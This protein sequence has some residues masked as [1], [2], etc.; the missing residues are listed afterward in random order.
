MLKYI[1][2][3]VLISLLTMLFLIIATFFLMRIIPGSPFI[4]DDESVAA[5]KQYEQLNAKYGLDKPLMEQFGIYMKGLLHGDMGDSLIKKGKSVADIIANTAVVTMRLGLVAFVFSMIVGMALGIT[6]A[7]SKSRALNNFVMLLS[8]IGVSVP[9]FLLAVFLMIVFAVNL[10]IFPTVGL[11]TPLHYVLPTIAVSLHPIAMISRLTR[12]SMMEVMRQDYMI[13][14]K[15][16]GTA[17]WLVIIKHGLRNALLPVVTYAGPLIASLLTGSFVVETLFSIPGIGSEFVS[18]VTNR[19][20]TLIMG[21]TIFMG[22][23]VIVMNLLSDLVAAVV[24]PRI[25]LDK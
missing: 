19:D 5:Q 17:R 20:Y 4:N 23:L 14:A 11:K 12:T 18:S 13:L 24:D 15:S 8:T 25:K 10:H 1:I 9:N 7:L 21:L 6:A 16:K 2:R 22:L 3:R